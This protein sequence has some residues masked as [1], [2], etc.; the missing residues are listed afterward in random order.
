MSTSDALKLAIVELDAPLHDLGGY[1]LL[2]VHDEL[3]VECPTEVAGDVVR[4]VAETMRRAM[5][6]VVGGLV[7]VAVDARMG[8]SW[9]AM[10][11][12]EV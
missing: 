5:T 9:G 6:H 2:P 1:I 8:P 12:I 11:G 4:L 10:R 3:L 7:R